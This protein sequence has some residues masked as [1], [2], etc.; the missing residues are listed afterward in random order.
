MSTLARRLQAAN[1]HEIAF[2]EAEHRWLRRARRKQLLPVDEWSLCVVQAG[3][4]FGKTL[5]GSNWVRRCAGLYPGC[6][7]HVIAPTYGD[8]RG[9]VFGGPSG[10]I[11]TIPAP[12]IL[13]I[14]NSIFEIRLVNGTIIK[15]FSAETPD[16]LRGPQCH[17]TWGDEAA[18]WGTNAESVI[19]NID[20]STRLFYTTQA[21]R[22]VQPQRLYTT[23][24]RPLEWL[25]NMI[26]R[27]STRVVS[28]TTMENRANLAEAFFNEL[29]QYEGT[30]IYRQEVLGELLTVG[31][32]AIIKRSWLRVW[33]NDRPLPWFDFV[34]V[35][36]DT[37]FTEATF[38]KKDFE[39]DFTAC[40]VWGVFPEAKRWNMMM[41]ECWHEQIGFPELIARAKREMKAR[42]GRRRDLLFKPVVGDPQYHEQVKTPDLLIIEDKG[43]GISL[44]QTLQYEGIDSWPYNPG[45]AD[46]LSRLHAIS[47]IAAAGRIW[48]PESKVMRGEPRSW[49]DPFLK[50]V[51]QYA[52]PGTTRNDDFV[53]SFSQA[54]RYFADRWLTS[55]VTTKSEM[56]TDTLEMMVELGEDQAL[57][58]A[59]RQGI[60]EVRNPYD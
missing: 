14:N 28:G 23:T 59:M 52:G 15:G 39:P 37:A 32:A 40:T 2:I 45:K 42:Y 20:L 58:D 51:T 17:F 36:L 53:D 12:M 22:R 31:E 10:L 26:E 57:Y 50:E 11:N 25:K 18:A 55:G 48:L 38:D 56:K 21:G 24:P 9:V 60:D 29:A 49:C 33:P 46:K 47:H 7:I 30:Q 19:S 13:S 44:R 5:V 34:Y 1:D 54:A 43:A 27:R 3:R 16:R 8:L 4:G 41:L 35:S 6:V